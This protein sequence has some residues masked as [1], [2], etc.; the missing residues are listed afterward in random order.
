[1]KVLIRGRYGSADVLRVDEVPEPSI[2]DD[3]VLVRVRAASV[4]GADAENLRGTPM[5]R[6]AGPFRPS[7][8]VLGSDIA[9]IVESVGAK[10]TR[11]K[12]GEAVFGDLFDSGFGAFA[13]YARAPEKALM[14]KPADLSFE[15]A[16]TLPQAALL[17]L[18][19]LRDGDPVEAG[20]KV[21]LNGAGGGAGSFAIQIAKA[22]GAH[23][24]AV[25]SAMKLDMMRSIGADAVIDYAE[26]DFTRS[27]LVY[28]RILDFQSHRSPSDY[29]RVLAPDGTCLLVGGSTRRILQA[30][31]VGVRLSMS[32]G[33][34]LGLLMWRTNDEEDLG[35][36]VDLVLAG[37]VTPVID[38]VYA[39]NEA[40]E[41]LRRTDAGEV[42]GKVV[43]TM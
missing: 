41:A 25:D 35:Y 6:I 34:R 40:A 1:M 29:R 20:Q 37:T 16:A 7:V 10:V 30:H 19:G 32:S 2:G 17:A 43:I 15:D 9:G 31:A 18:Q 36:L 14:P 11:F 23:V 8:K 21:L 26:Q 5:V 39:L 4:N 38:R 28:D 12:P 24:T 27:E 33:Q 3:D 13:E 42:P 22:F